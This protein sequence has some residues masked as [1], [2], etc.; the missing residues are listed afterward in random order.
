[1]DKINNPD[2]YIKELYERKI[3]PI[4]LNYT[5]KNSACRKEIKDEFNKMKLS[6]DNPFA[7]ILSVLYIPLVFFIIFGV[8]NFAIKFKMEILIIPAIF[9]GFIFI[10][11][12]YIGTSI[13][14]PIKK[15]L[16][17]LI[18]MVKLEN[19]I[20]K[21]VMPVFCNLLKN[22]SWD[23][24]C[25]NKPSLIKNSLIIPT[26]FKMSTNLNY[27]DVFYGKYKNINYEIIEVTPSMQTR[28]ANSE[29]GDSSLTTVVLKIEINKNYTGHTVI[30]PS[31]FEKPL[32][33]KETQM[34]DVVF[35]KKYNVFTNDEVE[36]R[37]IV[38]PKLIEALNIAREKLGCAEVSCAYYN[39]SLFVGLN[40]VKM[41]SGNS[42][43]I[44]PVG[45]FGIGVYEGDIDNYKHYLNIYNDIIAMQEAI[46]YFTEA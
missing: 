23:S 28:S 19:D 14:M 21:V 27:D 43:A 41:P 17:P 35:E 5:S 40:Y 25:Y 3:R 16:Q 42:S 9:I 10:P 37:Y 32:N 18:N 29:Y 15:M 24:Q 30:Y 38:T 45:L 31:V 6:F 22:I 39:K 36:A 46:E 34:E 13:A 11:V 7:Q 44:T 20:K 26:A 33:L 2:E 12:Y 4:I 1:M 8:V